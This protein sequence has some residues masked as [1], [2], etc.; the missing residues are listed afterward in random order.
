M[1]VLDGRRR[2]RK[3]PEPLQTV[4]DQSIWL[5][6]HGDVTTRRRRAELLERFGGSWLMRAVRRRLVAR[7]RGGSPAAQR[8][9]VAALVALGPAALDGLSRAVLRSE[10][11]GFRLRALA[12]FAAVGPYPRLLYIA[13][14]VH[15]FRF[16]DARVSKAARRLLI[17]CRRRGLL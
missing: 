17:T 11:A 2:R 9:S 3:L 5:L 7:L 16:G 13:A 14:L 15:L 4:V 6:S 10:D 12:V 1:D 8:R